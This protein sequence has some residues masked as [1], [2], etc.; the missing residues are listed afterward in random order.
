MSVT[1]VLSLSWL[2]WLSLQ[3]LWTSQQQQWKATLDIWKLLTRWLLTNTGFLE[4]QN[5]LLQQLILVPNYCFRTYMHAQLELLV[6]EIP[7]LQINMNIKFISFL[8][9]SRLLEVL[10]AG[11]WIFSFWGVSYLELTERRAGWKFYS[12][13][14][15]SFSSTED[16]PG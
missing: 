8:W 13:P 16:L 14:V 5:C 3:C 6:N 9:L 2:S 10:C 4:L 11:T 1:L 15:S 7:L 12:V